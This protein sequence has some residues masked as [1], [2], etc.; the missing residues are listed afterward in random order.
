MKELN[1]FV[2][3]AYKARGNTVRNLADGVPTTPEKMFLSFMSHN[4]IFISN[5][6]A[7]LNGSV[8]GVGFAPKVEYM[9]KTLSIFEDHIATYVQGDKEYQ[10]RALELLH[11][12]IYCE[13]AQQYMDF[14]HL[15]GVEMAYQKSYTNFMDNQE[16]TLVFY[17]PPVISYELRGK[18]QLIGERH[19]IEA[20]IS[21][22]DLPLIQRYLNAIHDVY[23]SPN[24]KRWKT[25]MAYKFKIEEIYDKSVTPNGWGKKVEL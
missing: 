25:R 16:A 15:Y 13:E 8:K 18:M 21:N 14:E 19:D 12:H 17:Q 6:P 1:K 22:D 9:E 24:P 4:P 3:W 5:G 7:G 10:T 20:D 2:Q 11:Q 23:H